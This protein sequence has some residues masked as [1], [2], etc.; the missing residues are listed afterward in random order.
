M[1]VISSRIERF[2]DRFPENDEVVF[3]IKELGQRLSNAPADLKLRQQAVRNRRFAYL[4]K[5]LRK[6]V[7]WQN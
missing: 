5:V 4:E 7:T 3:H 2:I 6:C 1:N